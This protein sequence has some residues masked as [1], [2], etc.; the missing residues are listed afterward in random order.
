M[1]ARK[2][3]PPILRSLTSID[4]PTIKLHLIICTRLTSTIGSVRPTVAIAGT[5]PETSLLSRESDL[6]DLNADFYRNLTDYTYG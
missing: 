6:R 2:D 3:C 1:I 5:I 4:Q